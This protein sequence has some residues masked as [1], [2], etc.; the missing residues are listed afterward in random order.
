MAQGITL[1]IKD[2]PDQTNLL[3]LNAIEAARAGQE[4]RGFQVVAEEARKL[5]GESTEAVGKVDSSLNEMVIPAKSISE[6][7]HS[8]DEYIQVQAA[9]TQEVNASAREEINRCFKVY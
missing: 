7:V 8:M 9:T 5:A 3:G 2:W 4:A 1:L 6:Q